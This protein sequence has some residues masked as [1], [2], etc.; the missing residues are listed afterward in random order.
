M[1][2]DTCHI[3]HWHQM[4]RDAGWF[5]ADGMPLYSDRSEVCLSTCECSR[6]KDK[7]CYIV[8]RPVRHSVERPRPG[9]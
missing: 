8:I 3:D 4:L 5:D 9:R 2:N 6:H 7:R 1:Q